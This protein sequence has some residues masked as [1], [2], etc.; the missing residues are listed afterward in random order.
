[1]K[2]DHPKENFSKLDH[3]EFGITDVEAGVIDGKNY[4]RGEATF[5]RYLNQIKAKSNQR[6]TEDNF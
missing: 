3:L 2:S 4:A 5:R 6:L 1:M